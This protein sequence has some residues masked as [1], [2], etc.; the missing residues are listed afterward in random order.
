M[1]NNY[2]PP[3]TAAEE[4]GGGSVSRFYLSLF[5]WWFLPD[6]ATYVLQRLLYRMF[7]RNPQRP[8]ST[9]PSYARH[10]RW[11]HSLVLLGYFIYTAKEAYSSL[12]PTLYD[13]LQLP[14]D[15]YT[16]Q[17]L[18]RQFKILSLQYHPDKYLQGE[19]GGAERFMQIR[20]AHE[21]LKDPVK[22]FTYD[23]FGQDLTNQAQ[24]TC[25]TLREYFWFSLPYQISWYMGSATVLTL[26]SFT[27][28]RTGGAELLWW[29]RWWGFFGLAWLEMAWLLD[30]M[31][32]LTLGMKTLTIYQRIALL[33]QLYWTFYFA[34]SA[35]LPL[36]LSPSS[37]A[38][39]TTEKA[40]FRQT[41][42]AGLVQVATSAELAAKEMDIAVQELLEPFKNDPRAMV[43]LKTELQELVVEMKLL[44]DPE[45][46]RV[47]SKTLDRN[48][49]RRII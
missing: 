40:Q 9:S 6:L 10:R 49:R 33:H 35:L 3:P 34:L 45:H 24:A 27:P 47:Y 37:S 15:A 31:P 48:R 14:L 28:V 12:S 11:L 7:Y 39:G 4:D 16:P 25:K 42:K 29:W 44:E 30:A 1:S 19:G 46:T 17:A 23:R 26:L 5:L 8:S 18:K 21:I 38:T 2:S 20:N 43:E 13:T 32:H 36:W 22:R 41:L